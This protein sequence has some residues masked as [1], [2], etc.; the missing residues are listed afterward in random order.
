[1][2]LAQSLVAA[3]AL[4]YNRRKFENDCEEWTGADIELGSDLKIVLA[5]AASFLPS[6][7]SSLELEV[8][9]FPAH[10]VEPLP[11]FISL[12]AYP[13]AAALAS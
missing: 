2:R 5:S 12:D 3:I 13:G 7:T 4:G 6:L 11:K 1:M 9:E 10:E 8:F